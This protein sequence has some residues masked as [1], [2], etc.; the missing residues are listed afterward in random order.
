MTSGIENEAV[1]EFDDL[2][3]VKLLKTHPDVLKKGKDFREASNNATALL[4]RDLKEN[5]IFLSE[6]QVKTK[7]KNIK[8]RTK[9]KQDA[10]RKTGNKPA[11][12]L[13]PYQVE[14]A[15][16]MEDVKNPTYN[17]VEGAVTAGFHVHQV[18]ELGSSPVSYTHLTL[19]TILL[20]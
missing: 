2:A 19:P 5:N 8:S 12:K 10:A 16:L 18:N 7:I 3:F 1:P 17:K 13:L 14:F 4:L 6:Q 20:V 11:P 15:K 9:D